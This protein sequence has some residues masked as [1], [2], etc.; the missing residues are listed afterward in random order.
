MALLG[1]VGN[2]GTSSP[3]RKCH[4]GNNNEAHVYYLSLRGQVVDAATESP[5]FCGNRIGIDAA[6]G[7][8][9]SSKRPS[10]V[11][12]SMQLPSADAFSVTSK[13]MSLS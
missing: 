4:R 11:P 7:K 6:L 2:H 9:L 13:L 10:I 3:A 1:G 5:D 12:I 8:V